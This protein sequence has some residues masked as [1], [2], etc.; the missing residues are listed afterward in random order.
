MART[1]TKK[2]AGAVNSPRRPELSLPELRAYR[3]GAGLERDHDGVG[4]EDADLSGTDGAGATFLDCAIRRCSLDEARWERARLLDSLL[5]GVTGVGTDLAGA[6]LRDVEIVDARL[7]GVQLHGAH[8]S[9]VVVRGGK[10]DFLNLRQSVLS[11]V[12]FENCVLVEPDFGGAKLDRVAFSGC[13]LRGVDFTK[14]AMTDVDLRGAAELDIAAGVGELAGAVV[15]TSQ[16]LDLAPAL[17]AEM[18]LRVER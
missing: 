18:G 11:D 14:A 3:Q 10:I 17:A 12:T 15:N 7:G 16:L 4:F 1:T 6:E 13:V 9:R 8:L 5:E 2:S